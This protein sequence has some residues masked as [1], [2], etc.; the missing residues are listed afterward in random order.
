MQFVQLCAHKSSILNTDSVASIASASC[1]LSGMKCCMV[2]F[3]RADEH[4]PWKMVR[5][6]ILKRTDFRR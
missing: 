3:W 1:L 5:E 2:S 6:I 4:L